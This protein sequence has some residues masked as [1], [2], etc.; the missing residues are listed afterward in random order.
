VTL[1]PHGDW[2]LKISY[3]YL[4]FVLSIISELPEDLRTAELGANLALL[5]HIDNASPPP[6]YEYTTALLV[7]CRRVLR[8]ASLEKGERTIAV[9]S[10]GT[11]FVTCDLEK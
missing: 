5:S 8:S 11:A 1:A 3:W 4:I 6:I 7:L 2:L 9:P 10:Y